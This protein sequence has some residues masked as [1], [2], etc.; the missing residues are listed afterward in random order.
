[1]SG[2]WPTKVVSHLLEPGRCVFGV[3]LELR[4][5]RQLAVEFP[6]WVVG[7]LLPNRRADVKTLG[8]YTTPAHL[9]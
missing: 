2:H 3:V 5:R 7:A 9:L 8:P 4:V 1:M 6:V